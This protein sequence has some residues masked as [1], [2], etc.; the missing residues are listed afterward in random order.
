MHIAQIERAREQLLTIIRPFHT[1]YVKK[2]KTGGGVI[3]TYVVTSQ[4]PGRNILYYKSVNLKTGELVDEGDNL[5]TNL[6]AVAA[7]SEHFSVDYIIDDGFALMQE[8]CADHGNY[9]QG[10]M[11]KSAVFG[12]C[13]YYADLEELHLK[14]DSY[15]ALR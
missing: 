10:S 14:D 13:I 7:L 4:E 15:I 9:S 3:A 6:D 12:Q 11:P 8:M 1:L 2:A 5:G